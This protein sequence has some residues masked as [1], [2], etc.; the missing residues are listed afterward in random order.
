M[1]ILNTAREK[2]VTQPGIRAPPSKQQTLGADQ[3]DT[4]GFLS[5]ATETSSCV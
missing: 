2:N 3:G 1:R 5:K 4:K